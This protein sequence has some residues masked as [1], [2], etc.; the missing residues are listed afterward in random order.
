[1]TSREFY[2]RF[3]TGE[4]GDEMDFV[5]WSVFWDMRQATQQRLDSLVKQAP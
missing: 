3:R 1:M 5:E 4:L 2:E